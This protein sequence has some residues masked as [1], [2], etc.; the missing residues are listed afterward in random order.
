M[1]VLQELLSKV[2]FEDPSLHYV[3]FIVV[4][5]PTIWNFLAR[6]EYRTHI[7]TKLAG[8]N[9]YYG[10]YA[11]AVWIFFF[12]L[13]RDQCFDAMLANQPTWSVLET[14][15]IRYVAAALFVC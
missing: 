5:A 13:Y 6:L 14:E 9:P 1:E 3:L 8:G 2:N 11:L 15:T 10:C 4:L 7:L 12:S